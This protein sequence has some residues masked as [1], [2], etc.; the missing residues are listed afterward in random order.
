MAEEASLDPDRLTSDS[1]Q[2]GNP[3]HTEAEIEPEALFTST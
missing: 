2:A 1:R 3:G